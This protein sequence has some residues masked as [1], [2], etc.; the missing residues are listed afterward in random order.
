MRASRLATIALLGAAIFALA[1]A[2]HASSAVPSSA[3]A[4][5][6]AGFFYAELSPF[7]DWVETPELGWAWFPRDARPSWRPYSDG[8]WENTDHGW[9]WISYEAF[10]WA[11]YHY[12]RWAQHARFGWVWVPGATW[13]PAWVAWQHGGG[14]IGWAPLPP[15]VGFDAGLGLQ[16]GGL[17]ADFGLPPSA[18]NFI[19]ER[20]FLDHRLSSDL[21]PAARNAA[22]LREAQNVTRY[23]AVNDRLLNRG[24]AV[25]AI[26][27]ATGKVVPELR[28]GQ[29]AVRVDA[30][31]AG[32]AI[33][34]YWP[35]KRKLESVHPRVGQTAAARDRETLRQDGQP[36]AEPAVAPRSGPVKRADARQ[37]ERNEKRAQ[38]E[39]VK[40][41]QRES[42]EL[43]ELQ[44]AGRADAA[45]QKAE[46]ETL[47]EAQKA[48]TEQLAERLK[49]QRR[50]QLAP[51]AATP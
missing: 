42:R 14:H 28:L 20:S 38:Q 49:V 31:M 17:A 36:A 5:A 1:P 23:E 29:S 43:Q 24:V 6:E 46:R 10:G 47:A 15:A 13:A 22:L 35:D 40:H 37:V 18:Y 33:W 30:E 8:R 3:S 32:Q 4:E 45:Q 26:E 12:G 19:P 39:L 51:P 7:G 27:A 16:G 44:Q 2:A 34:M 9:T 50:A 25:A 11:T 41:Q 21:V 48:A